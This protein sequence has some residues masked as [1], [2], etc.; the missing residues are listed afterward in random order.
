[1][2]S[3]PYNPTT[4]LSSPTN[5][6]VYIFQGNTASKTELLAIKVDVSFDSSLPTSTISSSLPFTQGDQSSFIPAIDQYG[7]ISVFS[8]DCSGGAQAARLWSLKEPHKALNNNATWQELDMSVNI[9]G[10]GGVLAG[11]NFLASGAAFA[12]NVNATPGIFAFGG[13]CPTSSGP[14]AADWVHSANYSNSLLTIQPPQSPSDPTQPNGYSL[15]VSA[16]KGP[17]IAEAGFTM[18]ALNPTLSQTSGGGPQHQSQNFVLVGG[19]TQNAFI[20]MSQL[21][22]LSLPEQSWTFL[23]V[24]APDVPNADLLRRD[25]MQVDS[26]SGHTTLISSDGK[27]LIVFGGWVGDVSQA[28]EPQYATL[29]I[30][31]GYGGSGDWKWT[32]PESS[33]SGP[34]LGTGIYGHGAVILPG[35]VMMVVGGYSIPGPT[36]SKRKRQAVT[37]SN[38][39]FYNISSNAW[40]DSYTHP[41]AVSSSKSNNSQSSSAAKRAG[42]GAGLTLGI[43]ALILAVILYFWYAKRTKKRREAKEEDLRRLSSDPHLFHAAPMETGQEPSDPPEMVDISLTDG[44]SVFRSQSFQGPRPGPEAERTGMLFEVPSPTR[45][46]RRSLHSRG[47]YQAAPRYE[48]GRRTPDFMNNIHPIDERDEYEEEDNE[49]RSGPDSDAIHMKDADLLVNV[50]VLDPFR[51]PDGSRSPSPQ[52][53]R[54]REHEIRQ[55]VNDWSAADALMSQHAGRLSPDKH[56]R[57]SS[58]LSDQS[59]RSMLSS[60]SW[61]HSAGSISR[62]MSQRSGALFSVTPLRPPNDTALANIPGGGGSGHKRSGSGRIYPA[63]DRNSDTPNSFATAKSFWIQQQANESP[64]GDSSPTKTPSRARGLMGSLRRAI[65]GDRSNST[66]PEHLSSS[67]TSPTKAYWHESETLNRNPSTGTSAMFWKAKQGAKDWDVKHGAADTGNGPANGDEWDVESAVQSRVVQLM[68]TVPKEKLR[69]VNAG[70]A[71]NMSML[72]TKENS[73]VADDESGPSAEHTAP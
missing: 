30:G 28:A 32:V 42:L 56:D 60:S 64:D 2:A 18:T 67:S 22:L 24:D 53:P 44:T 47:A 4:I 45:G 73:V 71:D 26:R 65:I 41:K 51:D 63:V 72:S 20:N 3:Y 9:F 14:T 27:S 40:I 49:D 13:M 8:G 70:D 34:A 46:L 17:P 68:F 19:H 11:A 38:T 29:E 12:A 10:G 21:A 1:M 69:V 57:T 58:T 7:N 5:N 61:Q 39:Y 66:S 62:T 54:A 15:S 6:I 35:N 23:P 16:S 55:W 48:M 31:Q 43:I 33:G 25:L 37:N 50:P 59:A 52:S 36:A